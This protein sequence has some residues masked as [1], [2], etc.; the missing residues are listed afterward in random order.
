MVGD[1]LWRGN[2]LW[3]DKKYRRKGL[4]TKMYDYADEQ[5]HNLTPIIRMV[6]RI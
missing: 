6:Q 5:G 1:W 4:A 2:D 3:V